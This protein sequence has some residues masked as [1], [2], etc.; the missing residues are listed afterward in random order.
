MLRFIFVILL[1][2][3]TNTMLSQIVDDSL[4]VAK[5]YPLVIGNIGFATDSME[6][7]LGDIPVGEVAAFNFEIFNFGEK[8]VL[9]TNG[10][11]NSFVTMDFVPLLLMP[12][13]VGVM[14]V[15]FFAEEGLALGEFATEISVISDD[16]INPYKFLN[17]NL[18]LIAGSGNDFDREM[19]DTVPAIVFD[20]Y[21][22]DYGHFVRG[23]R[24]YHTYLLKNIGGLPLVIDSII[25]P[26][27]IKVIERPMDSIY[28]N[29]EVAIRIKINTHGRVGVQ[30]QS[31]LVYSNDPNN[32]L[33]ILGVHGSVRVFP[34]HKKTSVQCSTY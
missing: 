11:S 6:V 31:V 14:N 28:Q 24:D 19:L 21:N 17:L 30:H 25:A 32:S 33:I 13:S 16:E 12:S 8:A 29:E 20:H 27:G 23:R 1:F 9:F 15:E 4:A 10:K 5:K 2:V 18:N 3:S 22:Y 34:N 26:K 7:N